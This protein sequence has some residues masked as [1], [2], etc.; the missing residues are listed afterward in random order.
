VQGKAKAGRCH[1]RNNKGNNCEGFSVCLF[2]SRRDI[3]RSLYSL[4]F[5]L[6][7]IGILILRNH[8]PCSSLSIEN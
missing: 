7:G 6:M 1:V 4:D 8:Q 5:D 2:L 3:K